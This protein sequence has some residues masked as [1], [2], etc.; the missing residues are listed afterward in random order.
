MTNIVS[1]VVSTVTDL[2]KD[3]AWL[4]GWLKEQPD[5]LGL[6]DLEVADGAS[7]DD[8]S[9]VATDDDRCFSVDV[10]L[11][12]MEAS[13]GF[14]VLDNWARNRVLH[15]DKTHVAVLVTEV[16]SDR[17]QTTL[18]T[19]AEHLPLVVVELQVWKGEA[20]AIVIPHVALSSD[21]VDLADTPAA[22]AAE[23][24][25]KVSRCRPTTS[26]PKARPTRRRV[27]TVVT[28]EAAEARSPRPK[29]TPKPR[30]PTTRTTPASATPGACPRR[31]PRTARS[32]PAATAR[33]A[34]SRRWAT[35]PAPL[36]AHRQMRPGPRAPGPSCVY[37]LGFDWLGHARG[38][39][40]PDV[41]ADVVR[42]GLGGHGDDRGRAGVGRP[43]LEV[44]RDEAGDV[45]GERD[46]LLGGS[47]TGASP[48]LRI[49]GHLHGP[50]HGGD[51]MHH[52]A[53]G[54]NPC[55]VPLVWRAWSSTTSSS[56]GAACAGSTSSGPIRQVID[57]VIDQARR[58]PTAGF[59]QGV[60]FLVLDE[61]G[62]LDEFWELIEDPEFP[63]PRKRTGPRGRRCWCW[64]GRIRSATSARYSAPDKIEFGM[65]QDEAWPVKFWDIDA[66]MAA[67]QLQ[68]AAVNAGID[69][70]FFGIPVG[71]DAVRERFG[72]PDDR[73]QVGVIALGYRHDGEQPASSVLK[74][75]R[76][77][78]EEQ[79]HRNGW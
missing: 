78:L 19:L 35:S 37:E 70:W 62:A 41:H 77:P 8:R 57:R 18:E 64:C 72:V 48:L 74:R 40:L 75:R 32:T 29:P 14:Q 1:G 55:P 73:K 39:S 38:D 56:G 34:C 24:V 46:A 76:R 51:R 68:L 5:R 12:E 31:M 28:G 26:S 58:A 66:G 20:E 30:P 44:G 61:P 10:Q 43:R 2:G 27:L 71:E 47:P 67:M 79:L 50:V 13:R 60:D 4:Q 11:G 52:S 3:E 16:M 49:Q 25:A 42:R 7:D 21:D 15:P 6:G 17:Y 54:D 9:F 59:S 69:T 45:D 23:V 22:K 53:P 63:S 33:P 65:D 36:P